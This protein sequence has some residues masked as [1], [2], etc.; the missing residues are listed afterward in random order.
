[1]KSVSLKQLSKL[2][3]EYEFSPLPG[4]DPENAYY[5]V[6]YLKKARGKKKKE[7]FSLYGLPSSIGSMTVTRIKPKELK[8]VRTV[9][10]LAGIRIHINGI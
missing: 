2:F 7:V 1:M 8:R 6:A 10:F 5:H 3:P 4:T 9:L